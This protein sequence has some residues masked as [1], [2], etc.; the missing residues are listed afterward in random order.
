MHLQPRCGCCK[1]M[2]RAPCLV[3]PLLGLVQALRA[4]GKSCPRAPPKLSLLLERCGKLLQT[5]YTQRREL[6]EVRV[7]FPKHFPARFTCCA[8]LNLLF[9]KGGSFSVRKADGS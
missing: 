1:G 5:W 8:T 7:W 2:P 6:M 4:E 3:M 9:A